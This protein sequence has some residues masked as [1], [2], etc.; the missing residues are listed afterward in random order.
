MMDAYSMLADDRFVMSVLGDR[1][2]V[3]LKLARDKNNIAYEKLLKS[4][5]E[6]TESGIE[7]RIGGLSEKAALERIIADVFPVM[8]SEDFFRDYAENPVLN[9][10]FIKGLV[11]DSL[12]PKAL[13][14]TGYSLGMGQ[15]G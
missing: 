1:G 13:T 8:M 9:E 11:K 10:K 2:F 7:S 14:Y 6:Y 15:K 4:I 5:A 3:K 12:A